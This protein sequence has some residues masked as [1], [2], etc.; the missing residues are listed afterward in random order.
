MPLS[1]LRYGGSVS[2][3]DLAIY[4][5]SHHDYEDAGLPN[6]Y[7]VGTGRGSL[8]TACGLY[9]N[10]PTASILTPDELTGGT[11]RRTPR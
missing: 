1:R 8:E 10:D 3:W 4:R 6:G 9:L 7:S 5:A 11:T 2:Q